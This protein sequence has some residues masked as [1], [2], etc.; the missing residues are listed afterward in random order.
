MNKKPVIWASLFLAACGG[1]VGSSAL[2]DTAMQARWDQNIAQVAQVRS[3]IAKCAERSNGILAGQ[4]DSLVLLTSGDFL[5]RTYTLVPSQFESAAPAIVRG[6]AAL[7]LAGNEGAGNCTVTLTPGAG[8][9]GLTWDYTNEGGAHCDRAISTRFAW[10][11]NISLTTG[12]RTAIEQCSKKSDG[13]LVGNC[14]SLTLLVVNGFLPSGY[15][16]APGPFESAATAF[17]A[18]TLVLTGTAKAGNCVVT[19]TPSVGVQA[20]TW[21]YT[22][23]GAGCNRLKTG[24]G[25]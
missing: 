21:T 12:M 14:D 6:T 23:G 5:P 15:V 22:N 24:V 4:C 20:V 13:K 8:T 17:T 10:S 1:G 18:G 16:V 2:D 7:V 19:I 9:Q 11:E 3:A 25:T